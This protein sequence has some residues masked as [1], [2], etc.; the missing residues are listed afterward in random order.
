MDGESSDGPGVVT[1][2]EKNGMPTGFEVKKK[3][4]PKG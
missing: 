3:A 2:L 1:T 4:N